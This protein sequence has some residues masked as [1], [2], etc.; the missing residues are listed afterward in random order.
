V[1]QERL[2]ALADQ[3]T[4]RLLNKPGTTSSNRGGWMM[5]ATILIEAWDLYA[6]SF[7]LIFIKTEYNP[8]AVE[9]GLATAAV[10]G[11]A[12]VG[13]LLGGLVADR[14][15][16]K[17]VFILTMILFIILAAAQGFSMNIWD[18][19]IIRFLLGIPLGS[20]IANGYAYIMESM[21]KGTR[22]KMGTRWQFMF[23]LGEVFAI[24]VITVMYTAG[25]DHEVLWRVGLALGAVPAVIL[26]LARLDLPETPLSL[27]HRGQF[28][29]AKE[30]SQKL[31]DDPLEML[32]NEDV[33]LEKVKVDD[34]LKVMWA[35]PVKKR[36]TIFGW[37]SNACQGAEFT[38]F[39][40]YLP[41]ILVVAG[42]GVSSS[43]NITG[44]NLVTALI[45]VLAT[46]SGFVAP[47]MLSA[48]RPP[49][50]GHVGLRVG[51]R[52]SGRRGLRAPER[53]ESDHRRG[54]VRV[55]VGPLLGR[56][57][58]DDHRLDGRAAPLQGHRLGLRLPVRQGGVVL[59]RLRLPGDDR[60]VG[61]LLGHAGRLLVVADRVPLGQ[62]HPARDVRLRGAGR[63][64]G[65]R[66][67]GASP[68]R[69]S[70]HDD[71]GRGRVPAAGVVWVVQ[72]DSS[73]RTL[74]LVSM[75]NRAVIRPPM[76]AIA[77]KARNT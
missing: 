41:V 51:V 26:L 69:A 28:V 76:R 12:L 9:L 68:C 37:I 15:G 27:L 62:V 57:E 71:S 18:L 59:R 63:G 14:L 50:P 65:R 44:T 20:D 10:Q 45:Y 54:R 21:S 75:A 16:R 77:A 49:R 53:L 47:L 55:D 70:P 67:G 72:G 6:I 66:R 38:A 23:G 73:S 33:K 52:G 3:A 64:R 74:F 40:F 32:P 46:I 30:M 61:E 60:G 25:I 43:G 17:R 56:L 39:A 11:G 7:L 4:V 34:F 13:A 35:D 48:H 5:I 24:L 42:V 58:R 2:R 36:A 1:D 29:K 19:I 31:F 8:S 22:E